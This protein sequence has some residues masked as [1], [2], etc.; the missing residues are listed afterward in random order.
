MAVRAVEGLESDGD[1]VCRAGGG[2]MGEVVLRSRRGV[3]GARVVVS[4]MASP[5]AGGCGEEEE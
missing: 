5:A 1:H 2:E 4:K 3:S